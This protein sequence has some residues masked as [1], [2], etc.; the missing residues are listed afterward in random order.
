MP[1]FPGCQAESSEGWVGRKRVGE[2]EPPK[3]RADWAAP[4]DL[5]VPLSG[6]PRVKSLGLRSAYLRVDQKWGL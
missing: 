2:E 5:Q 1:L 4:S 3:D 6:H